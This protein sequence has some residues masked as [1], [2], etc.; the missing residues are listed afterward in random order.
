MSGPNRYDQLT[1]ENDPQVI[2]DVHR[3]LHNLIRIGTI[4]EVDPKKGRCRVRVGALETTWLKWHAGRSGD[5]S[6]WNPPSPGEQVTL[7]S[8]SGR[9][10]NA[11]VL[12]GLFSKNKDSPDND[13]NHRHYS[14][15]DGSQTFHDVK[16]KVK[17]TSMP[18]KG[19]TTHFI[20]DNTSYAHLDG[21]HI[22]RVGDNAHVSFHKDHVYLHHTD[23]G[24][25]VEQGKVTINCATL[26]LPQNTIKGGAAS[27]D[28]KPENNTPKNQIPQSGG[29]S[30]TEQPGNMASG[31][32][33]AGSQTA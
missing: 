30:S 24:I 28:P 27:N 4:L 31:D 20:G 32:G 1:H 23:S 11:T 16:N 14:G 19:S 6:N 10:E 7:M 8:P 9:L 17:Q 25:K 12:P 15:K 26:L 29:T 13:E 33:T 21:E 2:Q 22:F 18:A 3:R 5:D